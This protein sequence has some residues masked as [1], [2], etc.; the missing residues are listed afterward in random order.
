MANYL[1]SLRW[2]R[3]LGV[4][5]SRDVPSMKG[6]IYA[7]SHSF[8]SATECMRMDLLLVSVSHLLAS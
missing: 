2:N 4:D 1:L 3:C 7:R 8:E 5:P 6:L